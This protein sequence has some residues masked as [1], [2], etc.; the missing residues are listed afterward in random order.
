MPS[1]GE[2]VILSGCGTAEPTCEDVLAQSRRTAV[3]AVVEMLRGGGAL[4]VLHGQTVTQDILLQVRTRPELLMMTNRRTSRTRLREVRGL[5]MVSRGCTSQEQ[6]QKVEC[7]IFSLFFFFCNNAIVLLIRNSTEMRI[8]SQ[9][10]GEGRRN[11]INPYTPVMCCLWTSL[12][13]LS[14]SA[15]LALRLSLPTATATS[16]DTFQ[17]GSPSHAMQKN[18]EQSLR[19]EKKHIC[20]AD[21]RNN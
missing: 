10:G 14:A 20:P 18:L 12:Y 6:K 11:I 13:Q 9:S 21:Q 15:L 8:R 1:S 3:F 2:E 19:Q 17:L 16:E 7:F 4:E 5:H